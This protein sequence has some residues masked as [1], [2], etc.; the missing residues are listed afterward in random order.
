LLQ[1]LP[2]R[3]IEAV[4]PGPPVVRDAGLAHAPIDKQVIAELRDIVGDNFHDM[5]EV[6]MVDTPLCLRKLHQALVARDF[7]ALADA[8]HTIKGSAKNL[9]AH[10]LAAVSKELEDLA[11]DNKLSGTS[12]LIARLYDEYGLVEVALRLELYPNR[13]STKREV[14]D[15]VSALVLI[16]DDDRGMRIAL[17]NA[18]ERGGFQVEEAAD[19]AQA[20][21]I[22]ERLSP[23]VVL[24]DAVM[25]V[26]DGFTAC[27]KLRQLPGRSDLPVL[28][29]TA[30]DDEA[31]VERAFAAGASDYIPKPVHFQ[32][33]NQR[34]RRVIDANRAEKHVRHLAY[35]DALTGLPNRAFFRDFLDWQLSRARRNRQPLAV[36]FLDLDRFKYINDT[37]G[38]DIG[39]Q[40]LKAVGERISHSVRVGDS[41][42]R[43][44]GDEFTVV[45]DIA[46]SKIA[47][48]VAE[49][50]VSAL[51][52]PFVI[53]GHE[54]FVAAS[55]GISIY[56]S[57]GTD[58]S[59]LLKH[60]DTAMYRAKEYG[61][62]YRFYEAGM[63]SMVSKRL[64]M[65]NNLRR[66][67]ARNE[68]VVHYQPQV[69]LRSGNTTGM[70]ALVR[71]QHPER[72]LVPPSEFIPMAEE[73]GLIVAIG[74]WVLLEACRQLKTW[75]KMGYSPIRLA[76]NLSGRQLAQDNLAHTISTTLE[77]TGLPA[78]LL[79]LEITES[80]IMQQA[81][82]TVIVLQKLKAIGVSLAID[83][84]G[85]GYSALSYLRRFPVDV[86]KIDRSFVQDI[87]SNS[88]DASIVTG[89]IA[90]AHSL[91]LKVV[92][93]G[94]ETGE[95][96]G[97]LSERRCDAIQGHLY[98]E[99]LPAEEF[100]RR[101]LKQRKPLH[102]ISTGIGL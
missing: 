65:E 99:A 3:Q 11:V 101:V 16:V 10:R 42:A 43:L 36:L 23:D 13:G 9:G 91:R 52:A 90:L 6:F 21:S 18:M 57:D 74:E 39:D 1:W 17:R 19:G 63:E 54:M 7:K 94:V 41:V 95:Q 29:V 49:K 100:E 45:L 24:M 2:A 81:E 73:T 58:I 66:A 26:M 31:S 97:I 88:D 34:V 70:E 87:T 5:I 22:C 12:D 98:S 56:P 20:L 44:G 86:L 83:D 96:R 102:V 50:I 84:F 64:E 38:H 85:T 14:R 48:T 82:R 4:Q 40:L 79:E 37:L 68:L 30:L 35:H 72:G 67:L 77:A 27:S 33:L 61:N 93:E 60:A 89:I 47:A 8:T 25:P 15:D 32:V 62:N 75:L 78:D 53:G 59:T 71:W 76:V 46:S 92:A 80:T 55:I 69:D 51:S 28:I